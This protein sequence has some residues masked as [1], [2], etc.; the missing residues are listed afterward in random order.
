MHFRTKN[1]NTAFKK[2]VTLFHYSKDSNIVKEQSRNGPVLMCVEPVTLTY[3]NPLER[4]LFNPKRDCNPFFH[5]YEALWMLAGRN[6][7]KSLSTYTSKMA[8]Y[9]DDGITFNGAYGKRWYKYVATEKKI[10]ENETTTYQYEVSNQLTRLINHLKAN[11]TSRRAV[12]QMWD[13]YDDLE[14]VDTSKDVCCNLSVCFSIRTITEPD[15]N[16]L[17]D[18]N[19]M[20]KTVS[21]LDMT[22]FNR[23]NDL[24]KGMLGANYVHFT[25]L[26]EYIAECLEVKVGKYNQVSNNLHVY[27]NAIWNPIEWLKC[28]V[29]MYATKPSFDK[30]IPL[31]HNVTKLEFDRELQDVVTMCGN[32]KTLKKVNP[33]DYKSCF[34]KTVAIPVFKAYAYYKE[35]ESEINHLMYSWLDEI[36]LPDWKLAATQ[37]IN[38]RLNKLQNK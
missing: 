9:S 22:V 26:Q 16:Y 10:T 5:M 18:S 34:I 1:V 19:K 33:N 35:P 23:S 2:L 12:L 11:P 30:H 32:L 36:N 13:V 27:P 29:N 38:N 37:W 20:Y 15:Q 4:V 28:N 3:N 14:K 21:Y 31:L 17:I 7:V 25:F 8:Q 6:D 24:I